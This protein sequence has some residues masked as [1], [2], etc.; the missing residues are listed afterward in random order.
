MYLYVSLC[1]GIA[2]L[3]DTKNA[4][5]FEFS[6]YIW[7]SVQLQN[8]FEMTR[9]FLLLLIALSTSPRLHAQWEP[10]I[11]PI[12]TTWGEKLDTNNVLPE[13][14]RPQMVR[15]N[16]VN[17]NG[18]WDFTLTDSAS[19]VPGHFD[20]RILVPFCVEST[21]GGV[22]MKVTRKD[23]MWYQKV[24]RLEKP[25]D[26]QRILLHFGGVDWHTSLWINGQMIGEHA[27]AYDPFYF[28]VTEALNKK[29]IQSITLRVWDPTNEGLQ[30]RG[31]QLMDPRGIWYTPVSGIW[32]TVW[33]EKVPASH[34]DRIRVIPDV[35]RQSVLVSVEVTGLDKHH[36]LR[37]SAWDED[38]CLV[39]QEGPEDSLFSLNI[40]DPSLWSPDHPHLYGLKVHLLKK[41]DTVDEVSSYF[42]MRKV[43]IRK[44]TNGINRIFLNNEVL[45][46]FGPLDQGWWPGGL[47]TAAVD[48][49][50]KYDIQV[51]RSLGFNTARKH[52]KV[53][54]ARWYYWCDVLGLMV[55]QDMPRCAGGLDPYATQDVERPYAQE[56]IF[57]REWEAIIKAFRHF[58]SIIA[59][60]PFNE[61]WG[62][63]KTNEI[64]DWTKK[65]DT[66]RLVDGPSGW[67]DFG[68][69]EMLDIHQYPGPGIPP[70]QKNRA[71]V[72]GEFGGLKYAAPGHLWQD[73]SNWGYQETES[74]KDL[75]NTYEQLISR[76]APLVSKGIAAAIYTQTSDVEA[77]V[78][79]LMTYDRKIV[80]LDT[81]R[82]SG[83]A[84]RLYNPSDVFRFILPSGEQDDSILWKYTLDPPGPGWHAEDFGDTSWRTGLAGFGHRG[85][86]RNFRDRSPWDTAGIWLRRDFEMED[87]PAG[88]LYLNILSY[89]AVSTVYVNGRK[90]GV[91]AP[92]ENF[93]GMTDFN[94]DLQQLL[95]TGKNTISVYS[96]SKDPPVD[97]N[98]GQKQQFIDAG[99]IEVL[100]EAP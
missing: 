73:T 56:E 67:T 77:E 57:R 45:F 61:G 95:R 96:Y 40:P 68:G 99:I 33:L 89:H 44:D 47:Y 24:L 80:K 21:L 84:E 20:D 94:V 12:L 74:L 31:K 69:G 43:E 62:Q 38:S 48:D 92:T 2:G 72:L 39:I 32:Q 87:L 22:T 28:D 79:G 18:T 66:T 76:L 82:A 10:K 71:V 36:R 16:W 51:T 70:L 78:N 93:Y 6:H 11:S 1:D 5:R 64:M 90:L 97:L 17:L 9:T 35:D 46:N 100:N 41:E 26:G 60:V 81:S 14:P 75:N 3:E 27:G 29:G 25:A 54:P 7:P 13:Y 15:E 59:W 50:L 55:W 88:K 23:A 86:H 91:Y 85:R 98:S 42:G 83:L 58:P 63:F 49:A 53:E 34:I 37:I 65:L 30:P 4:C 8:P 52:T 19:G